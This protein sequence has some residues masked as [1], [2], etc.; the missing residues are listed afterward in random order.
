MNRTYSLAEPD[1][2]DPRPYRA[3][4]PGDATRRGDAPWPGDG[5]DAGGL[6]AALSPRP[7]VQEGAWLRRQVTLAARP[8]KRSARRGCRPGI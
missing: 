5:H 8:S 3:P 6:S 4:R 7:P 2:G 1:L